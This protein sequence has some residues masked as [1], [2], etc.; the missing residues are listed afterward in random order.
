MALN[1]VTAAPGG[2]KTAVSNELTARGFSV[3]DT[4][5]PNRTGIAGWHN[6]ASGEYAYGFNEMELTTKNL[7]S[8][9][10]RL[11]TK[12]LSEFVTRSQ[13]ELIYL[14]GRLREPDEVIAVSNNLLFLCNTEE[15]IRSR[16]AKRAL[17][18]GEVTWGQEQWQIERSVVVN[19]EIEEEYRAL[20]AIMIDGN[21]P[22]VKVADDI[23]EATTT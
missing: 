1:F 19:K 17:I 16:L 21:Q 8:H 20:G 4:D 9:V 5:D 7:D 14:C 12:C 3:Y 11:T 18:P 6:I 23:L 2:G 10:W 15:N 13:T 22:I